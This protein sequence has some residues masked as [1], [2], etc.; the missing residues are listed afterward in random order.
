MT[1]YFDRIKSV[2]TIYLSDE[3]GDGQLA[4][5]RLVAYR[6]GEDVER[7]VTQ[8]WKEHPNV[9]FSIAPVASYGS[10]P[11]SALCTK[12][13]LEAALKTVSLEIGSRTEQQWRAACAHYR[14]TWPARLI[15]RVA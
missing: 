8:F 5:I 9:A 2:G 14:V 3:H 6:F 13:S 12:R 15:S 1:E 7:V 10:P 11:R 4:D